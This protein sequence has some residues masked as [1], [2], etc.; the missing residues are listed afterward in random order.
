MSFKGFFFSTML[1]TPTVGR[2]IFSPLDGDG[3]AVTEDKTADVMETGAGVIG[4]ASD[5][6]VEVAVDS[7]FAK[8]SFTAPGVFVTRVE[9]SNW[10][11]AGASVTS[12]AVAGFA[13]VGRNLFL[14]RLLDSILDNLEDGFRS[15][16][17]TFSSD[18]SALLSAPRVV[19]SD[20]RGRKSVAS[21]LKDVRWEGPK[22]AFLLASS[23]LKVQLGK[24]ICYR[25]NFKVCILFDSFIMFYLG[26]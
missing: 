15:L 6:M 23:I 12:K 24:K 2:L 25:M 20:I 3:V 10:S 11:T 22:N 8:D 7:V 14:T 26:M 4:S 13:V 5:D 16:S 18:A 9:A 1:S 21:L 17:S 19:V